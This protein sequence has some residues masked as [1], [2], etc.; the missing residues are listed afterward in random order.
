[1]KVPPTGMGCCVAMV[2]S[3]RL[4]RRNPCQCTVASRSPP[5]VTFTTVDPC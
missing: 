1:M 3:Y 5:L 2:P 4:S